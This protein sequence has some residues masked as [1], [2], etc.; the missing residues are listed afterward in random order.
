MAIMVMRSD[1]VTTH[2]K[3]YTQL[4]SAQSTQFEWCVWPDATSKINVLD[5]Y[6]RSIQSCKK[7]TCVLIL[8]ATFVRP[9][10][11]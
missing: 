5:S 9:A 7:P 11:V 1:S 8:R 4:S 3:K 10:I 6:I 2:Y